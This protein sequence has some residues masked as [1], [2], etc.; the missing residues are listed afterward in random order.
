M[1]IQCGLLS[2]CQSSLHTVCAARSGCC[3]EL[4]NLVQ[5]Y[6][7]GILVESL[8]EETVQALTLSYLQ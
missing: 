2:L 3:D 8:P 7:L 4:I 6:L 1:H 5:V